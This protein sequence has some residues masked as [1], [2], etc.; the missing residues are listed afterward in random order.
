MT[1]AAAGGSR[2]SR[3]SEPAVTVEGLY[4][5]FGILEVLKG[6][7]LTAREGDVVSIIGASGFGQKRGHR[8]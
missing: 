7:S 3:A 8:R 6:V 1:P 5:N 4:K 2:E